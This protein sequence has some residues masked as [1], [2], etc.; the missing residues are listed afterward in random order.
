M[1]FSQAGGE[2]NKKKSKKGQRTERGAS[3]FPSTTT[4]VRRVKEGSTG[5]GKQKLQKCAAERESG[6]EWGEGGRE[7]GERVGWES[8]RASFTTV[9]CCRSR[10]SKPKCENRGEKGEK[11]DWHSPVLV[12]MSRQVRAEPT[13]LSLFLGLFESVFFFFRSLP[14]ALRGSASST[15]VTAGTGTTAT[16]D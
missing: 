12:R 16:G 11:T 6:R 2:K 3:R 9:V 8:Y 5:S 1:Y 13:Q 15:A 7:T 14:R 4:R 10:Y